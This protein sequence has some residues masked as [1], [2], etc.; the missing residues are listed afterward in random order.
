MRKFEDI[1]FP[2]QGIVKDYPQNPFILSPQ[3]KD[4]S[5]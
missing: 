4:Y 1:N 3:H 2:K 5:I